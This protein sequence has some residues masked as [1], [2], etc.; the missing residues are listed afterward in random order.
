MAEYDGISQ[1]RKAA[2]RRLKDAQELLQSPSTDPNTKG[3]DTRHLRAAVYL[4]GYAV[5]CILKV[6]IISRVSAANSL[7]EAIEKRRDAGEEIPNIL[8]A[9]GH[10]LLTLLSLTDLEARFG[11]DDRKKDWSLCVKWKSTWR[12]DP[13]P[14]KT[15]DALELVA[16]IGRVYHW[17]TTQL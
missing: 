14:P 4:T 16:A 17:V 1:Y 5:E 7:A 11:D 9:E 3:A 10:K 15:A 8:G 12:Y 6:Y 2:A 13:E